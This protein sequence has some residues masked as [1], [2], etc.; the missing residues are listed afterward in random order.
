MLAARFAWALSRDAESGQS[1][2][3]DSTDPG[4]RA[5]YTERFEENRDYATRAFRQAGADFLSLQTTES[6]ASALLRFFEQ[7]ARVG[8]H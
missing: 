8:T 7:R 6:Y 2:W 3:I 1:V 4:V 5:H